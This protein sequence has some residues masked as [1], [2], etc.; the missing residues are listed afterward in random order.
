MRNESDKFLVSRTQKE[1]DQED[2]KSFLDILAEEHV[3]RGREGVLG[4]VI[5]S[6]LCGVK[7]SLVEQDFSI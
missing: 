3:S 6:T 7:H 1:E 2:L 5:T 4:V